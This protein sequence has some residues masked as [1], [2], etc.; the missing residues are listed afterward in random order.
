MIRKAESRDLDAIER[1]YEEII[2]SP[3]LADSSVGWILGVYPT[4]KTAEDAL[5]RDDLFVLE[6]EGRVVASAIIN[7]TQVPSYREAQWS[8][9]AEDSQV[10]VLHTLCVFPSESKKGYGRQFVS[11]YEDYA[12]KYSCTVLRMDT[13]QKNNR[14]RRMYERLGYREAGIVGCTFQGIP[15]VGLVCLEKQL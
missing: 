9:P 2:L 6:D 11:F 4:R 13:N 8:F 15:D 3:P 1:M 7:Q 14:A 12:R 5:L 10:M